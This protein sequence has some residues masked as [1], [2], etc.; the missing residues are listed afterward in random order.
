MPVAEAIEAAD[1][2]FV[3]T[4]V[5]VAEQGRWATFEVGELWKGPR[6]TATVEVRGGP[7]IGRTSVDRSYDVGTRY[8][9]VAERVPDG[10]VA[11]DYGPGAEWIDDACSATQAYT[12]SVDR[13]RPAELRGLF[14][15][16]TAQAANREPVLPDTTIE[17]DGVGVAILVVGAT[18]A[19]TYAYVSLR[20]QARTTVGPEGS[21]QP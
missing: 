17:G 18:V 3:G 5:T 15:S 1:L 7:A 6:I 2:V 12:T 21:S 4:V 13:F 10:D 20:R 11:S 19:L 14:G 9:V 8:L 16:G